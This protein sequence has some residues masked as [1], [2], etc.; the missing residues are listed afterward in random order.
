[1]AA[2]LNFSSKTKT[3]DALLTFRFGNGYKINVKVRIS[4]APTARSQADPTQ[5]VKVFKFNAVKLLKSRA[6]FFPGSDSRSVFNQGSQCTAL[7]VTTQAG[8]S[9]QN[10]GFSGSFFAGTGPAGRAQWRA[11]VSGSNHFEVK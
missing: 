9:S 8:G 11:R 3:D 4:S 10:A 5:P 2:V 6:Q 7:V 1:M